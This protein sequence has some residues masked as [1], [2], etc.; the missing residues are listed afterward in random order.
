[1]IL[2]RA[3][4]V[5]RKNRLASVSELAPG[6]V[7]VAL[8]HQA[9]TLEGEVL[10]VARDGVQVGHAGERDLVAEG[11]RVGAD[12]AAIGAP[13]IAIDQVAHFD[14]PL[15]LAASDNAALVAGALA[16]GSDST[17]ALEVVQQVQ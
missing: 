1:M 11:V 8:E 12:G 16:P 10:V 17:S 2:P 9:Q 14:G 15:A 7:L 13:A 4:H 5:N 6:V 3:S